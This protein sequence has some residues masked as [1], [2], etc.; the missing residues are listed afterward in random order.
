MLVVLV[1]RTMM[2]VT[3]M[4]NLITRVAVSMTDDDHGLLDALFQGSVDSSA[5]ASQSGSP[6]AEH[7]YQLS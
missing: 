7:L 5:T 3:T 6:P 4:V 2:A 1:I